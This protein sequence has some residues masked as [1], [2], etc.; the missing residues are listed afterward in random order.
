V[1][2]Q[3][4]SAPPGLKPGDERFPGLRIAPSD[5]NPQVAEVS[6]YESDCDDL[7]NRKHYLFTPGQS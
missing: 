5:G 6:D 2:A 7:E 4:A 3:L 1:L